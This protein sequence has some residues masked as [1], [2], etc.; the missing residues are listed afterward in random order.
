[1]NTSKVRGFLLQSPKPHSVRL[2]GAELD[3]PKVIKVRN[4]SKAAETIEA[5]GAELVECLD[6]DGN[7]LR[8][9]KLN[10][11]DAHRSDAAAIPAGIEQD[12]NALMLT[13]FAN[14]LHRAY[15]HSSEIAFNKL[16][17]FVDII[18]QR[19]SSIEARLERT[20]A[21]HRRTVEE[22]VQD[23]YDRAEEI[24]EKAKEESAGNGLAEQ[25]LGSFASGILQPK[26]P[27]RNGAGNGAAKG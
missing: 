13:H 11:R 8:A 15:E 16:C 4:Y 24:A 6:S 10:D 20:E 19:T 18:N 25:M 27:A 3:D 23:A 22:Q 17:E 9:L 5:I 21:A 1:M 2:T 14:L 12:P 7:L 26:P